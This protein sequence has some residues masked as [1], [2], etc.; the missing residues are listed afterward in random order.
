VIGGSGL[1]GRVG[2]RR[3]RRRRSRRG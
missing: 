1:N 3:R 2:P